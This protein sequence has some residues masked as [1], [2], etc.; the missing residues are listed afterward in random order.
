MRR[1][2]AV[3]AVG[4]LAFAGIALAGASADSVTLQARSTVVR[5]DERPT[6]LGQISS[7]QAGEY[8]AVQ[9]KECG[10]PGAFFRAMAGATTTDGGLW[11]TDL[12]Y[13]RT[14][15]TFRAVWRDS[16][17]APVTV[18]QRFYVWLRKEHGV[19][20]AGVSSEVGDVEGDRLFIQRLTT[21]G[22]KNFKTLVLKAG[23]YRGHG[24]KTGLRFA[25]PKGTTLRAYYPLSQAKPCYLAGY[26]KLIR[27]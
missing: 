24:E 13:Q 11:T 23:G 6:L 9:G 20:R 21:T 8:V 27:T 1:A 25:L 17:S 22:W 16:M 15:T 7:G 5:G 19:Y 26:S 14:T 4:A 10:I 18:R 12:V 2:G 3:W